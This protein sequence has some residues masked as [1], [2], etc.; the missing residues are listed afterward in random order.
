MRETKD[1]CGFAFQLLHFALRFACEY[2]RD[3]YV[4]FLS[5]D[6][7]IKALVF[8]PDRFPNY[9]L[10][11]C[12]FS[13]SENMRNRKRGNCKMNNLNTQSNQKMK[14]ER[15]AKMGM[16][17][18]LACVVGLVRFPLIPA[19]SFLTYDFADIPVFITTFA[20]GP[21]AGLMTVTVVSA[22]QAFLLGGDSVY[23]FIMH[24]IASGTF[25][26]IAGFIYRKHKTKKVALISLVIATLA[27]TAVM[28]CAN[29]IITPFYY[30]GEAMRA[31]VVS[32]MPLILLFNVIKGVLN[33]LI[34][35]V[36]YKRIS[37]FLHGEGFHVK[38]KQEEVK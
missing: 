30:G 12:I 13:Q 14:S 26:C 35:F 6:I 28:G 34:T 7:T 25:L 20:F 19:V 37:T 8:S 36:I 4:A 32:L 24:M 21:A 22:I 27:M 29:Y 10:V 18:A 9:I 33:S 15:L 31:T 17:A 3:S 5:L 1:L 38:K 16:M 11:K 2:A 23:G